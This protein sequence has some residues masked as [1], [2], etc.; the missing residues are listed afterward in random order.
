M[1]DTKFFLF[2]DAAAITQDN[3]LIAHGIFDNLGAKQF[4]VVHPSMAAI[5]R[6]E[7][8][9]VVDGAELT[10]RLRNVMA[11]KDL[12][13]AKLPLSMTHA[14]NSFQGVVNLVALQL[15]NAGEYHGILLMNGKQIAVSKLIVGQVK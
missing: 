13:D 11:E 8:P 10:F 2:C 7:G 14:N 15:E 3:K 12:V 1:T 4:P 9:E 5:F 6:I